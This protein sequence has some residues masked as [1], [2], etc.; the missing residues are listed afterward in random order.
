PGSRHLTASRMD[1]SAPERL[2]ACKEARGGRAAG[3]SEQLAQFRPHR[4]AGLLEQPQARFL[5]RVVHPSPLRAREPAA[6][7]Q[8][9][10]AHPSDACSASSSATERMIRRTGRYLAHSPWNAA[11]TAP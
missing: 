9:S 6:D 4:L 1:A 7:P 10:T 5:L 3:N 11:T 8:A 2:Q